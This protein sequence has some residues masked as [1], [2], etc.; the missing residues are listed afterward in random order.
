[1]KSLHRVNLSVV[2]GTLVVVVPGSLRA[3]TRSCSELGIEA[4]QR[5]LALWPELPARIRDKFSAREDIDACARVRLAMVVD[6]I[7]VDVTLADGRTASR[8]SRRRADVLP[9]LEALLLVLPLDQGTPRREG[10]AP[11]PAPANAG[12]TPVVTEKGRSPAAE[13]RPPPRM[14]VGEREAP[15]SSLANTE[16]RMG[17]ELSAMTAARM[18]DGQM[19]LGVG[20]L[21]FLDLWGWL[22]GFQGRVDSFN[23]ASPAPQT[24]LQ[25]ALLAGRRVRSG[26]MALDFIAGPSLALNQEIKEVTSVSTGESVESASSA[27]PR[28]LFGTH[29]HFAARSAVRTFVGLQGEI[30]APG[31][32]SSSNAA[33]DFAPMPVWMVGLALGAT[34]GTR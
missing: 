21:S 1:M 8:T 20:V 15:E 4:D 10:S 24:T 6:A 12:E 22:A 25:L 27:L 17:V 33:D 5:L 7:R 13:T 32:T 11:S 23:V 18:G 9:T 26:S 3:Q 34:V 16:D 19:S 28:L 30:G 31:N 29:L 2:L 14:V